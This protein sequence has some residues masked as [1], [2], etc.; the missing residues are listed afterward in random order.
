MKCRTLLIILLIGVVHSNGQPLTKYSWD[1]LTPK[2]IEFD[3]PFEGLRSDQLM[4]LSIIARYQSLKKHKP[5][6]ISESM[7]EEHDSLAV[8]LKNQ[9]INVDSL[10][11][12][13][14]QIVEHSRTTIASLN[15][16]E[17][18]IS[19]YLLPLDYTGD[20]STEFLLVPWVG[21]CIHSPP[22]PQNQIVYVKYDEGYRY[23]TQY[24]AVTIA[25]KLETSTKSSELYLVDGSDQITSGYSMNA[26][27]IK[28]F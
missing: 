18:Q 1:D 23:A 22:P 28:P 5:E 27:Q 17:A 10:F 25:G 8:V 19:G 16:V 20:T 12:V 21:A 15:G 7:L 13:R 26:F 6:A 3:D 2:N 11:S 24:E 14:N 4:N 9:Q